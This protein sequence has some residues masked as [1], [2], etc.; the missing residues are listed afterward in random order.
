MTNFIGGDPDLLRHGGVDL[1]AVSDLLGQMEAWMLSALNRSYASYGE[2]EFTKALDKNYLPAVSACL[3][4]VRILKDLIAS[5][6][7]S[8]VDSGTF[9]RTPV[10]SRLIW[11]V[12]AVRRSGCWCWPVR[13]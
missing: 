10:T 4:F 13:V 6:G 2:D 7:Q 1:T 9:C 8:V 3:D 11:R 12:A 5:H